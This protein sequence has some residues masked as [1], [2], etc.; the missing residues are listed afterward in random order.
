MTSPRSQCCPTVG[1]DSYGRTD[2]GMDEQTDMVI[3]DFSLRNV[4]FLILIGIFDGVQEVC[5]YN[6]TLRLQTL[7]FNSS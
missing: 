3:P 2:G 7:K 1:V 4:V 5:H 6:S